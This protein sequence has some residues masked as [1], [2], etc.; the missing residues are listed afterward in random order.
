MP[1]LPHRSSET[2]WQPFLIP[3]HGRANPANTCP[4]CH[5]LATFHERHRQAHV[6]IQHLRFYHYL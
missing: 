2:I 1:L 3:D 6:R 4:V 5:R